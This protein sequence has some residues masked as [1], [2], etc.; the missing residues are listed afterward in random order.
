MERL[1]SPL[2]LFAGLP[3][4]AAGTLERP[5]WRSHFLPASTFAIPHAL[6]GLETGANA[7]EREVCRWDGKP[8]LRRAWEQ[9]QVLAT[10]LREPPASRPAAPS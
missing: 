10:A 5:R 3:A 7:D 6:T 4:A 8:G 9:D 1:A 2:L